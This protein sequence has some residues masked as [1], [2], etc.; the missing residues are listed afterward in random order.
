M[1]AR[2]PKTYIIV[3]VVAVAFLISIFFYGV[4]LQPEPITT[5]TLV[6][7][8]SDDPRSVPWGFNETSPGPTIVIK[9][10]EVIRL[11]LVNE[12]GKFSLHDF[13]VPELGVPTQRLKAGET[14]EIA[15]RASEAGTFTYIC[16]VPGHK[17]VGMTGTLIVR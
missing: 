6:A 12:G 10:G 17:E 14:D 5:F 15:F 7:F 4:D 16:T 8:D 3:D 13:S 11:R 9:K 1:V 2:A